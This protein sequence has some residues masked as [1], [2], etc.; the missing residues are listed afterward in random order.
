MQDAKFKAL[1]AKWDKILEREG[2]PDIEKGP[3]LRVYSTNRFS[4]FEFDKTAHPDQNAAKE[5]YYQLACS[6]LHEHKFESD[7]ERRIW[8]LHSQAVSVREIAKRMHQPRNYSRIARK[9]K[10]LRR[11]MLGKTCLP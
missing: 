2:L 4:H 9:I 1:K 7:K 11:L 5:A 10:Q 8:E 3:Y 6:F